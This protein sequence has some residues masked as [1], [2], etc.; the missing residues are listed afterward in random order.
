VLLGGVVFWLDKRN[1]DGI[2]SLS[3]RWDAMSNEHRTLRATIESARAESIRAVTE[4]TA[5]HEDLVRQVGIINSA[6]DQ[7][8]SGAIANYHEVVEASEK[9]LSDAI[10]VLQREHDALRDEVR[11]KKRPAA[12][13]SGSWSDQQRAATEGQMKDAEIPL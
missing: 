7:R 9:R 10:A 6:A 4:L 5:L 13:R 3:E 8:V 12:P 2:A 1:R 11:N